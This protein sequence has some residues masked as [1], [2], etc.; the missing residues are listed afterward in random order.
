MYKK[1]AK[2]GQVGAFGLAA[3]V[4]G[5]FFI[6]VSTAGVDTAISFAIRAG[7]FILVATIAVLLL[8][9]L[10]HTV[11]DPKGSVKG[12]IGLGAMVGLFLILY[13]T[14]SP[15]TAKSILEAREELGVSDGESK[16][17]SA[18]I[19]ITLI[20]AIGG[21]VALVFSELRNLVK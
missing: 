20:L 19:S 15:D 17:I 16:F 14:A 1:L 10:Y 6:L 4:I 11:T 5:L 21:A 3:V 8:Y 18:G 7:L 12:L 9:T 2:Y 13:F